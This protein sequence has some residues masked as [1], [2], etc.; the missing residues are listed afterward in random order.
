MKLKPHE[1]NRGMAATRHHGFGT[2]L[3]EPPEWALVR[4][5]WKDFR[6]LLASFDLDVYDGYGPIRSFAPKSRLN[7]R[8][9]TLLHPFDFILYTGLVLRLKDGISKSRLSAEKVFSYRAEKTTTT[10]LYSPTPS[11]KDFRAAAKRKLESNTG[12]CVGVT[13]IADFFP[14]IYHHFSPL[15]KLPRQMVCGIG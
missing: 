5:H 11:M 8:R 9:V 6:T 12:L 13:D 7:V 1:L 3:P 14:R 15:C 4:K 2:F 10:Q